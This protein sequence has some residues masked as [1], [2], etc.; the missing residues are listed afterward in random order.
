M[1]M[2]KTNLKTV[3]VFAAN[4]TMHISAS[5]MHEVHRAEFARK[6]STKSCLMG[7]IGACVRPEG[8][9]FPKIPALEAGPTG[10]NMALYPL[11]LIGGDR[12]SLEAS[13]CCCCLVI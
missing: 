5:L 11:H 13:S 8:Q 2:P 4:L 3:G 7:Q 9:R 12:L 10:E 6:G 1:K